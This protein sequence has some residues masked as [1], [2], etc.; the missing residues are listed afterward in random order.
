MA[1]S[2]RSFLTN[3]VVV[4]THATKDEIITKQ[5]VHVTL[6]P[7]PF[8]FLFALIIILIFM[9]WYSESEDVI[10]STSECP[11]V[12]AERIREKA[13][14]ERTK[15]ICNVVNG[16]IATCLLIALLVVLLYWPMK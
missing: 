9:S 1:E 16:V 14:T 4:T 7:R 15:L 12:T 8:I 10:E 3:K 11:M 2:G 13:N 5:T 6:D